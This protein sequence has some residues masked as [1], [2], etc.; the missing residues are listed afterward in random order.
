LQKISFYTLDDSVQSLF[1][2]GNLNPGLLN[3][4]INF[5]DRSIIFNN[6]NHPATK[7][8]IQE[9]NKDLKGMREICDKYNSNLIFIN[10]PRSRFT[11][12]TVIR[13]PSDVL[14]SYFET[15]NRVD[16]IYR[17]IADANK[18]PY[19]ELT[20]HFIGLQ[21]K[22]EYF[23]RYDGHPN[24]KGYEEIAKYLGKQLVEQDRLRKE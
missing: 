21:N 1:K 7:F 2:S 16:S 12:H 9:M 13:T 6:P 19:I 3:Y 17:S 15:N 18:L 8:S 23:F 4:Y 11:G 10:L 24:K 14:N 20:D 22:S 5:P